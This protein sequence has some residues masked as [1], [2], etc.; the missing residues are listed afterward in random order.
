MKKAAGNNVK[1]VTSPN[2]RGFLHFQ[3]F[4]LWNRWWLFSVVLGHWLGVGEELKEINRLNALHLVPH[5]VCFYFHL[6]YFLRLLHWAD[7]NELTLFNFLGSFRKIF[8][9][10]HIKCVWLFCLV[11]ILIYT[12]CS[13]VS[14][15]KYTL[16]SLQSE[17]PRGPRCWLQVSVRFQILCHMF[18]NTLIILWFY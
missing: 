7:F 1:Q 6:H 16:L 10:S 9:S 13:Q 18:V 17:R 4:S 14:Q 3:F 8:W 5:F 12:H 15:Q 2:P 11:S